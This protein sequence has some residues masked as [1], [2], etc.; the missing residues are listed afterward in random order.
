MGDR[1]LLDRP[2]WSALTTRRAEFATGGP[3]A[4][5]LS[6]DMGLFAAAADASQPA[7]AALARLVGPGEIVGTVEPAGW[8]AAPGLTPIRD[9]RC[10]QMVA[11]QVPVFEASAD[12]VPLNE[13]DAP[14]MLD[15][16]TRTEPGPFRAATHRFGG[17]VGVKQGGRLVAMAG[18]RLAVPGHVE[19]SGVCTDPEHRGRGYARIL[20]AHV[21][22]A[23][24]AAGDRPF[25]HAYAGHGATIAL[26]E[27][28]GFRIRT[29]LD[30]RLFARG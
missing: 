11:D 1:H 7:L 16:A 25:L 12:I 29:E 15:L 26:Y 17:F 8:P 20:S 27:S 30:Y 28:L 22:R 23:I 18:R 3:L 21:A 10:V 2:V 13:S 19:L 5:R 4:H 9:A 6:P 24:A 14:A